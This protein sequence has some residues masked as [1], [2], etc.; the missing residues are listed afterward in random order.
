MKSGWLKLLIYRDCIESLRDV[1]ARYC[2]VV[3]IPGVVEFVCMP[4]FMWVYLYRNL[5]DVISL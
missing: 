4:R 2:C 1:E 3:A 5:D